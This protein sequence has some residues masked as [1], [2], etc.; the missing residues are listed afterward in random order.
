MESPGLTRS[1]DA[2]LSLYLHIPFCDHKCSYCDFNSYAGLDDLMPAYTDALV[3]EVGR[4][5]DELG[6]RLVPTVFFGGGTPSL[7]PIPLLARVLAAAQAAFAFSADAEIT[8]EA[9]PGT[10]DQAYFVG[11]RGLGVNRV[12][13]GVQSFED[14]ELRVLDRIHDGTT[15]RAAY[16]AARAA[17]FENIN[18]DL[19]FGLQGQGLAGWR[20]TLEGAVALAPEHLSLYALTV[21][22]GTGLAA[23]VARGLAPAPDPDVQAALYEYTVE[24]LARAGY[25]QYEISNWSRPGLACRHNLVYWRDGEWLGLGAGAHSHLG[26]TRFAVVRSPAGYIRQM[27]AAAPPGPT[28]FDRMPQVVF[29]EE[30]EPAIERADAAMLALRLVAGLDEAAFACRFGMT[31]D[32]AFGEALTESER[33]GLVERRGGVTALTP[34]G[35]LLA[36]EV[37]VRLLP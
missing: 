30:V 14:E 35:R 20:R 11:L 32:A 12:S 33:L 22:E 27:A 15:A 16:A 6:R 9:N 8:L 2:P 21:E 34:G 24:R 1:A 31:P 37:F 23:Q 4:W 19:I 17:G 5:G 29:R 26:S 28:A 13:L 36:N 7:L 18:L 10:V 3:R 25:E